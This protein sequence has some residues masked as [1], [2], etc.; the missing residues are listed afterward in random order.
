MKLYL[1]GLKNPHTDIDV[2][3]DSTTI[4]FRSPY[5]PQ[6][7]DEVKMFHG[8]KWGGGFDPPE[9]DLWTAPKNE[10]NLYVLR[11]L[12]GHRERHFSTTNANNLWLSEIGL[13]I[14][15]DLF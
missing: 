11:Y 6:W 5:S 7:V 15:R 10:R 13:N 9:K 4:Y 1:N 3:M 2:K 8:R 12:Q 14:P